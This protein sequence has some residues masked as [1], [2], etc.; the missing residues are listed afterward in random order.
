MSYA[1]EERKEDYYMKR[2][3]MYLHRMTA[4]FKGVSSTQINLQVPK[5]SHQNL[6][7]IF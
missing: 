5:N 1:I 2:M 6:T 7:K 3:T 4:Y